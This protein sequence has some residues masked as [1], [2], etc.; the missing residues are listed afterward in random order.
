MPM[1]L[2]SFGCSLV[3]GSDL[4]DELVG[5]DSAIGT[6]FPTASRLTWPAH[7]ARHL[8]LNYCCYARPGAGNLQ[9][10]EQALNQ[11]ATDEPA[12]FVISW[13]WIDRFDYYDSNWD[14]RTLSPWK[15]IVPVDTDPLSQ[16]YYRDI[17]SEYRDKL[18]SLTCIKTVIDTLQ[19]KNI[20]FVM[21][22]QDR[23][24][25]DDRWHITMGVKDL[26]TYVQPYMTMFEDSTFIEWSKQN[27]F[28]ISPTMHPL[29]EAHEA[30]AKVILP[31]FDKQKIVDPA[32]L[33]LS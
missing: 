17:H 20:P 9:I 13:S 2:K 22:Y 15:T 14:S 7:I 28:K 16:T 10:M 18:V 11:A 30:A 8:D 27:K 3:F 24:L 26:Q 6:G 25:F 29:E 32:Q 5:T 1:K 12:V 4:S 31:A 23:L 19:Q 21:T 33:V